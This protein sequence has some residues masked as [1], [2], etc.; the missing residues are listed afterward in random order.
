MYGS[1]AC[2]TNIIQFLNSFFIL[3]ASFPILHSPC[4]N[5]LMQSQINFEKSPKNNILKDLNTEQKKAV[6]HKSGPLL[7]IAGAGT[8]KTTVITRRIAHIIEQKLAKPSEILAL[9]FTEKAAAEME[10][11]VDL[12]VPYGYTDMWISTFHAFGDKLLRDFS[13]DLGLPANFKVLTSTEQAIFMRENIYAFDLKQLRPVA[14]PLTH[15]QA[16]L[17][18]F[19]RLKDELIDPETYISWAKNQI[20]KIKSQNNKEELLELE[21]YLELAN[22]YERYQDLMIQAGNLDFGDQIFLTH[23]LLKENKKVL[24]DCQ[25][26]FKFILV[27]EYQDTN[28]AQN[29][30]VKLL[31]SKSKNITVVGDDDQSIYRFR[32]ASI[33]N[34]LDFTK[35]FKNCTQIVLNKNYRSTKQILNSSYKLIRHNNPERLEIK[36]KINKKLTSTLSGDNPSLMYSD[37][38][39]SEADSVIKEIVTL[40]KK[41]GYKFSDFA[42]LARANNHTEPFIQALNAK[43][44]PHI[45]SGASG[46]F[47]QPEIKMILAFL[48]CLAYSDDNLSFYNLATSKIYNIPHET[49]T[50]YYSI[51]KRKNRSITDIFDNPTRFKLTDELDK[52]LA[53]LKKYREKKGEPVGETLYDYLVEKKYL[54]NL[55]KNLS[56]ENEIEIYN[57]AKLF[58]RIA[59]F[60]RSS[61]ER[62]ALKFLENIEL[63]LEVGDDS[64]SSDID[65]DIDAVNILTAHSSKGLEW[66]VVFVINCVADRF[67]SR[68]KSEQL[69]IPDEIIKEKVP[70]GNFHL[71]EERR[72]FYVATTRAKNYLFLTSAKDYG[73]KRTKKLSPFVLELLDESSVGRVTSKS[74][75]MQKILMHKKVTTKP[76]P[77]PAKFQQDILSLSRQQIDDY[78]TCP[79]KFYYAHIVKI[80]LLENHYLMYGTAIHAALDHY[81]QRKLA[82]QK[83]DFKQLISDF[84]QTFRNVGFITREHEERRYKTGLETL[85]RFYNLDQKEPVIPTAVEERFE[86]AENKIKINGRYDLIVG[87]DK[88]ANIVDFKTSRVKDQKDADRRVKDSTQ[89]KIYALAWYKKFGFIPKSTLYFIEHDLRGEATYKLEQLKKTKE[90]ILEVSKG[91]RASELRA[92]P[93]QRQCSLCPY[94]DICP[95][96]K[97]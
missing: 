63:I 29:E 27:D 72:L 81:F 8:G 19:S 30:I 49:M 50:K 38:L 64:A 46:L 80:P 18:H 87:K 67:P 93:A 82:G 83:P 76:H 1:L 33:S 88:D 20:S 15:I 26:K 85:S 54:K 56:V 25:K 48:K 43:G 31:A 74:D 69:P 47:S 16:M 17:N 3:H 78:Y 60:N 84:K 52:L 4:Y 28:F 61:E 45:F 55:I 71:Q 90:M 94:S 70:K 9:T 44:I 37:T 86:F 42:L 66:P 79:Q 91:I 24:S 39:S 59:E 11:R 6:T 41:H 53:D 68:R 57:I 12:L 32:G 58:D 2:Y 73:G 62:G 35:T 75:P 96:S 65:P 7:I 40:K 13:I 34:I 10:E 77:I 51:A 89:M 23:K 5:T 92:K 22:A 36:N 97:A 21:K 14:N 95:D